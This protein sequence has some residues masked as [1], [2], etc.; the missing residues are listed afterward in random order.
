MQEQ[1]NALCNIINQIHGLEAKLM[2]SDENQILSR[3]FQRIKKSFEE[4]NLFVYNPMGE[5]YS[6]TRLD[7]EASISGESSENLKIIEVIKPVIYFKIEDNNELIQR[8]VV[9]AE[10]AG[11]EN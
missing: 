2:T 11:D 5:D 3:R 1:H 9:I 6:E 10:G 4:L 7:C 8:A